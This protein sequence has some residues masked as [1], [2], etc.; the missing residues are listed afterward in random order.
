[1]VEAGLAIVIMYSRHERATMDWQ[2]L[3]KILFR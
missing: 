1:M 2:P 3:L